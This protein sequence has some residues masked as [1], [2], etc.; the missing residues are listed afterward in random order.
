MDYVRFMLDPYWFC[1]LT[2]YDGEHYFYIN[3]DFERFKK[4]LEELFPDFITCP[5]FLFAT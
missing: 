2:S 3:F 1:D 5:I 4:Y